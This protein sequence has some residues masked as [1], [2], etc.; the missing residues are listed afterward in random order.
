MT[1][2]VALYRGQTVNSAQMV[3]VSADAELVTFVAEKLLEEKSVNQTKETDPITQAIEQG[4]CRALTFITS[5][6]H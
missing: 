3:A 4:R 2:F 6:A 1:T 5:G